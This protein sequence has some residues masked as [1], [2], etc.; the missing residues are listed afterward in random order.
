MDIGEYR[1]GDLFQAITPSMQ[2][3]AFKLLATNEMFL[4]EVCLKAQREPHPWGFNLDIICV[5]KAPPRN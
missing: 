3:T 2:G 1:A 4:T 5:G